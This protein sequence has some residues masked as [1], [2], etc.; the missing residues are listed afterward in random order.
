MQLSLNSA[1]NSHLMLEFN[2]APDSL[3]LRAGEI[4]VNEYCCRRAGQ[5][6]DAA[7]QMIFQ[8]FKTDAFQIE[9]GWDNWSGYYLLSTSTES[10]VILRALHQ[11]LSQ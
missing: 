9:S 8:D 2:D 1:A 10:D 3:W 6:C 5:T 4:L 11:R 7:G